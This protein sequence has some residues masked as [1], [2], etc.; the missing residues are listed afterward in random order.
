MFLT[1]YIEKKKM[2]K[3]VYI[4]KID[5]N[6]QLRTNKWINKNKQSKSNEHVNCIYV[7]Y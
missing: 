3:Y 4:Y 7:I 1:K 5:K 2:E 6:K